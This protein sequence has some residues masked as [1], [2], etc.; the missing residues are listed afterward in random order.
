MVRPVVCHRLPPTPPRRPAAVAGAVPLD[1]VSRSPRPFTGQRVPP[2]PQP[3]HP[4]SLQFGPP[5][6]P[7]G[8]GA[9]RRSPATE[10]E[11]TAGPPL[12]VTGPR[13]LGGLGRARRART[14]AG[15]TCAARGICHGYAVH[16]ATATG[17]TSSTTQGN[18][19]DSMR[20]LL[21]S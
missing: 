11:C 15:V 21:P 5:T 14:V 1:T 20:M 10:G 18:A 4:L 3:P 7:S 16:T 6:P 8:T 2:V 13:A 19:R 9:M 17:R 12:V